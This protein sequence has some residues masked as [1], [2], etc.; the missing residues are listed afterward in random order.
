MD[1]PLPKRSWLLQQ[2]GRHPLRG[3]LQP[4]REA[5]RSPSRLLE[6]RDPDTGG[7][8]TCWFVEIQ[9]PQ[10]SVHGIALAVGPLVWTEHSYSL[11]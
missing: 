4:G 7:C 5:N 10:T 6:G 8:F 11:H 3:G 2:R 9:M 1:G